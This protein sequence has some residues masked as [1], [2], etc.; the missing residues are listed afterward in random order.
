[1]IQTVLNTV[2]QLS[3]QVLPANRGLVCEYLDSGTLIC[4]SSLFCT[5]TTADCVEQG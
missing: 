1:M 4:V 3:E 2:T 5:S